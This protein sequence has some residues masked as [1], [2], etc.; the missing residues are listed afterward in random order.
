MLP[1]Y[2]LFDFD[3]VILDSE[4]FYIETDRKVISSFGYEPTDEELYTFMG[5]SSS[6]MGTALLAAHGIEI[7][8]EQYK[9]ARPNPLTTIYDNP[10]IPAIEG[11]RELWQQLAEKNVRIGV[12]STSLCA[13]LAAALNRLGLMSFVDVLVGREL[14]SHTKPDPEPFLKALSY[15][16][17]TATPQEA[18]KAIAVDD[19]PSGIASAHAAG[20]YAIGFQGSSVPQE[21][22]E[23]DLVVKSHAELAHTLKTW[24]LF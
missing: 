15:L 17:P 19:S 16:A 12:V 20:M 1:S 22:P 7:T 8:I 24:G 21:L 13:P 18:R 9:A 6:K 3:G 14:V 23:A 4:P 2:A 5:R 11:L 10:E